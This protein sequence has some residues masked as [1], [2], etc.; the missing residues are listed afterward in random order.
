MYA[1]AGLA[2]RDGLLARP[3]NTTVSVYEIGQGWLRSV[4]AV[5][6]SVPAGI[7]HTGYAAIVATASRQFCRQFCREKDCNTDSWTLYQARLR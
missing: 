5:G 6:F 4:P 3:P 7:V 2:P 1:D